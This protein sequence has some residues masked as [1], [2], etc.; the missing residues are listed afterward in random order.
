MLHSVVAGSGDYIQLLLPG[1]VDELHCVARYTDGE[2]CIL[3]LLRMLHGIDKLLTTEYIHIE[4]M[5]TLI[6]VAIHNPYQ[7]VCLLLFAV[8]QGFRVD[9]LG[10]GDAVQCPLIGQLGNR[11]ERSQ[12]ARSAL[13]RKPGWHREPEARLPCVRRAWNRWPCRIPHW[14]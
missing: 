11:V 3:F 2:V 13:R 4:V 9:G 12:Q 14:K 6:E 8:A 1:Q 7:I 5:R 10:I